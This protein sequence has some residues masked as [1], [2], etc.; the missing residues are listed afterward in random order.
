MIKANK[1]TVYSN[2]RIENLR[3]FISDG[4]GYLLATNEVKHLHIRFQLKHHFVKKLFRDAMCLFSF[5]NLLIITT[6]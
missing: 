2:W 3:I 5:T 4:K 1:S 6:K